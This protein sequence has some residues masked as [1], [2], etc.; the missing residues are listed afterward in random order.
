MAQGLKFDFD[1]HISRAQKRLKLI[2]LV[3]QEKVYAFI[4]RFQIELYKY[5]NRTAKISADITMLL[6][7]VI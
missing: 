5:P 3:S 6:F 2:Y 1:V 4:I 7:K